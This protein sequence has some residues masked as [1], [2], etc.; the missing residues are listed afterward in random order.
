MTNKGNDKNSDYHPGQQI[1]RKEAK[2]DLKYSFERIGHAYTDIYVNLARIAGIS[3]RDTSQ[4]VGRVAMFLT[5]FV[6]V[7]LQ[8]NFIVT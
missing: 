7:C 1:T 3:D 8:I 6:G 5:T 4:E 2:E